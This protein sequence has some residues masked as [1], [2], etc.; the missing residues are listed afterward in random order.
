MTQG[1]DKS[2]AAPNALTLRLTWATVDELSDPSNTE[3]EKALTA[4]PEIPVAAVQVS[5]S[6]GPTRVVLATT[7]VITPLCV[8]VS[9]PLV[10]P[11]IRN[12]RVS[13]FASSAFAPAS[14]VA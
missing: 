1:P 8:I 4:L 5:V 7:G 6:P 12:R 3:T 11:I 9:E 14:N 13:L 10:T 2:N